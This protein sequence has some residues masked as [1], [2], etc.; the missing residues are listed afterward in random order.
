MTH[1]ISV[2]RI[3]RQIIKR[4]VN[5]FS[6]V[7]FSQFHIDGWYSGIG[8]H[9]CMGSNLL[10]LEAVRN[11]FHKMF[12]LSPFIRCYVRRR[13]QREHEI[14]GLRTNCEKEKVLKDIVVK[15]PNLLWEGTY[16]TV[17]RLKDS[18]KQWL[19]LKVTETND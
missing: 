16:R 5:F 15:H 8:H 1:Q 10:D 7:A 12:L 14:H 6:L 11:L 18:G 17:E 13:V 4:L 19:A 9:A 2:T 3:T